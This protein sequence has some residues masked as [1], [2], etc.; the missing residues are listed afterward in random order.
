M[1]PYPALVS[2]THPFGPIMLVKDD[3]KRTFLP[4]YTR[5]DIDS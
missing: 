5:V 3:K 1:L 4:F 2:E